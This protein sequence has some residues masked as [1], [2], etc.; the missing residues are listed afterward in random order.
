MLILGEEVSFMGRTEG[1]VPIFFIINM[2]FARKFMKTGYNII[3]FNSML[4]SFVAL[5]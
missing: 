3:E 2:M 4:L 5:A 1:I